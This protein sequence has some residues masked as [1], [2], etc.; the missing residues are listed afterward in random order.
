MSF[1]YIS[2]FLNLSAKNV[3]KYIKLNFFLLAN[4]KLRIALIYVLNDVVQKAACKRDIN[5]TLTFHP[6]LI[7][8][9]TISRFFFYFL[10][11]V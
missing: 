6:H 2:H 4:D 5:V 1:D 3:R 11:L 7:N 8:A 10:F 9:T